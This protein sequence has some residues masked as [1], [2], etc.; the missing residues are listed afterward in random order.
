MHTNIH[1]Y[2]QH[3]MSM[4]LNARY[5]TAKFR[6]TNSGLMVALRNTEEASGASFR[7]SCNFSA[8]VEFELKRL[9]TT[10]P[11]DSENRKRKFL[12]YSYNYFSTFTKK[13]TNKYFSA[14][15][16]KKTPNHF[17]EF[18]C[19]LVKIGKLGSWLYFNNLYDRTIPFT[20]LLLLCRHT[21]INFMVS[22][23]EWFC[24][25]STESRSHAILLRSS[26]AS[27]LNMEVIMLR[28]SLF[29][30]NGW[31]N[32]SIPST[33]RRDT[34]FIVSLLT[35]ISSLNNQAREWFSKG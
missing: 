4:I 32:T 24:F 33:I 13:P 23:L 6:L 11:A 14:F 20:Q 27:F 18:Y 26:V 1:I 19:D 9:E 7:M 22:F 12:L 17:I 28:T 5:F 29:C 3:W 21:C 8:S 15:T 10:T 31:L 30:M 16:K 35:Q 34:D 25:Y 2:K